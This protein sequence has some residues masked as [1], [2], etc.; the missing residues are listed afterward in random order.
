STAQRD[1]NER[2]NGYCVQ[3]D[4]DY[5][6]NVQKISDQ[7]EINRRCSTPSPEDAGQEPVPPTTIADR[8]KEELKKVAGAV[9]PG[10][11]QAQPAPAEPPKTDCSKLS[12]AEQAACK[13]K[14]TKLED[15]Q[16]KSDAAADAALEGFKKT[17][18]D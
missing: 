13:D 17:T 18:A 10:G 11:A 5:I 2:V 7:N 16:K 9:L 3:A 4:V 8:I 14:E 6:V 15:L 1:P 12:G